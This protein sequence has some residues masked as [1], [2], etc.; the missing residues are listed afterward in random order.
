ML[1]IKNIAGTQ[2]NLHSFS[3]YYASK[4]KASFLILYSLPNSQT[5]PKKILRS[6][7]LTWVRPFLDKTSSTINRSSNVVIL[8]TRLK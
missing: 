4:R 6:A 1:L 3:F 7:A 5:N 2:L 8:R